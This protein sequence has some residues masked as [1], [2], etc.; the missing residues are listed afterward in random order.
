[1]FLSRNKKIN[2]YPC[3]PQFCYIKVG[4]KGGQNNIGHVCVMTIPSRVR[5]TEISVE[6]LFMLPSKRSTLSIKCWV[7]FS[8]DYM[9]ILVY[10][11]TLLFFFFFFFFNKK[12]ALIFHANGLRRQFARNIKAY[13]L[14]KIRKI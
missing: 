3:K 4:L 9:Y 10:F 2:V 6:R 13:F 1:M 12:K 7:H 14:G 5:T 11:S 8:A